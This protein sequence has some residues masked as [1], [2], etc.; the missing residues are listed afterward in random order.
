MN[1]QD[2]D[3]QIGD[4]ISGRSYESGLKLQKPIVQKIIKVLNGIVETEY[5]VEGEEEHGIRTCHRL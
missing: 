2:V 3:M 1:V 4:I 5:K